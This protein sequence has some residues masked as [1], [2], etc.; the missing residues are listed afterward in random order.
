MRSELL[1]FYPTVPVEQTHIVGTPQ[2][3]AYADPRIL[4]A[5]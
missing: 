1:Q 5:A 4:L 2:F 3:D